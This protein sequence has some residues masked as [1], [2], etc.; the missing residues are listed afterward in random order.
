MTKKG[1]RAVA[2]GSK[3]AVGNSWRGLRVTA[4]EIQPSSKNQLN[5]GKLTWNKAETKPKA[6][7]KIASLKIFMVVIMVVKEAVKC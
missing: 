1:A 7:L 2:S 5:S 6:W 4:A 3:T